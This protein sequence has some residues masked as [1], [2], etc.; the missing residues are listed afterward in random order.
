[1][2]EATNSILGSTWLFLLEVTMFNTELQICLSRPVGRGGAMGA[3]A[4]PYPLH[5]QL[6]LLSSVLVGSS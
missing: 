6:L 2:K 3:P 4:H 5:G 1:M